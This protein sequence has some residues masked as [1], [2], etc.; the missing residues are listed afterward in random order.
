MTLFRR[1]LG[2]T[3]GDYLTRSRLYI[4]QSLLLTDDRD[5]AS[6]AFDA[7]FGSLSRFHDAFRRQF[8]TTPQRFRNANRAG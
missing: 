1:V 5:I 2:M 3:A 8:A 4:A 6:V 7:G